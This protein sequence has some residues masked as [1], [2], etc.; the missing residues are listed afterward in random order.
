MLNPNKNFDTLRYLFYTDKKFR[1]L[2]TPL[3]SDKEHIEFEIK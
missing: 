2:N 1:I 3:T